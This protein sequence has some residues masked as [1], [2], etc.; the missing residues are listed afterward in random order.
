MN[1]YS[2]I[3]AFFALFSIAGSTPTG[4]TKNDIANVN[5]SF[6]S[7]Y[8]VDSLTGWSAG[9][10]GLIMKTTNGGYTWAQQESGFTNSLV[11]IAFSGPTT[12]CA[13]SENGD[14]LRTTDG[15]ATWTK[16]KISQYWTRT[17]CYSDANNVW[18]TGE[19]GV[20][21]HSSNA[22]AT[23]H[24]QKSTISWGDYYDISF[25]TPQVGWAFGQMS[26]LKTTDG[27]QTWFEVEQG[28]AEMKM[29]QF[30][31]ADY[32][33]GSA[34]NGVVMRTTDGGATWTSHIALDGMI[35]SVHFA[36][37]NHGWAVGGNGGMTAYI[38]H[39]TDGGQTWTTEFQED[40]YRFDCV[41]GVSP[42]QCR[43][44]GWYRSAELV[45]TDQ[46]FIYSANALNPV[47]EDLP[48]KDSKLCI[49]AKPN[50][51]NGS[52]SITVRNRSAQSQRISIEI[53]GIDGARTENLYSSEIGALEEIDIE[54]NLGHLPAGKYFLCARAGSAIAREEVI[55]IK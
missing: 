31:D 42:T 39:T 53:I 3:I 40:G 47:A 16:Q 32:G 50:E 23:W 17:I 41:Y 38:A 54:A 11:D 13:I 25:S 44:G 26:P 14:C 9:N 46:F 45:E 28:P 6:T 15:G 18:V 33:W 55:I 21:V 34:G 27:G 35:N 19:Y 52:F 30:V 43:V 36:D 12:G 1:Y 4:W 8:F 2:L 20:I 5:Y 10:H 24:V 7:I 51:S 37:R 29:V 49:A 48:S 22:G